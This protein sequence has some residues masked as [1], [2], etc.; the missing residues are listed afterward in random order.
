LIT[1]REI[2]FENIV[3]YSARID[4]KA[5]KG[6]QSG[7]IPLRAIHS[8]FRSTGETGLDE[9]LHFSGVG[10]GKGWVGHQGNE[11][12]VGVDAGLA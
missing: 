5:I 1:V 8:W 3:W 6:I 4:Q 9:A 11:H 7:T 12:I 2:N 10:E